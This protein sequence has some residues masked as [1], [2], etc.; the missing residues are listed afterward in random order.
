MRL[1]YAKYLPKDVLDSPEYKVKMYRNPENDEVEY[2]LKDFL[3]FVE[4][5]YNEDNSAFLSAL[6]DHIKDYLGYDLS[7]IKQAELTML[8]KWSQ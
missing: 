7:E 8:A 1:G 2:I 6:K 3:E 4:T 5:E